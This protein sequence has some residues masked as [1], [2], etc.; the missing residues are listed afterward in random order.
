M[1][2][3]RRKENEMEKKAAWKTMKTFGIS[4]RKMKMFENIKLEI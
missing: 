2:I 3:I 1:I 4:D